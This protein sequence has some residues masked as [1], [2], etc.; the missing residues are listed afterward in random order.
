MLRGA[1]GRVALEE[2]FIEP[3]ETEQKYPAGF[4]DCQRSKP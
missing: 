3:E 1:I 4:N 2:Q